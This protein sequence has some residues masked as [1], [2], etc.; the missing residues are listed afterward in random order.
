MKLFDNDNYLMISN[1]IEKKLSILKHNEDF[2]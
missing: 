1:F 2:S